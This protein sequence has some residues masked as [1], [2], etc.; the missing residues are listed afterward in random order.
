M[1]RNYDEM[2]TKDAQI[3]NQLG[4][5]FNSDEYI[6]KSTNLFKFILNKLNFIHRKI[7]SENNNKLNNLIEEFRYNLVNPSI[8]EISLTI[9]EELNLLEEYVAKAKEDN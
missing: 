8:D 5:P 3:L 6:D 9:I 1:L 2:R 4:K 7:E